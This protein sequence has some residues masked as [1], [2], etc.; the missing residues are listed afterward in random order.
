MSTIRPF[1][2]G[3]I[4]AVLDLW[5]ETEGLGVGPGDTIEG[6]ARLLERNPGCSWVASD[7]AAIAGAILCGHDGRRGHLY[8]LAIAAAHRRQGLASALVQKSLLALH[9]AGIERCLLS[10]LAENEAATRFW[11]SI[12]ARMRS[13]LRMLSFDIR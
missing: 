1:E 8:H 11:T 6:V 4:P 3:D 5:R 7:G 12:G 9:A 13:E 10:V 2:R